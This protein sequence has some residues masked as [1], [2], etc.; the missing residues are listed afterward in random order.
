METTQPAANSRLLSLDVFRGLAVAAMIVVNTPGNSEIYRQLDHSEWGGCTVADLVFPFFLFI[1]GVSLV[2]SLSRRIEKGGDQGLIPQILKRAA[3]IYCL[4][5]VLNA[6]PDY[7]LST[8][9]MTG[10]LQRI[11]ICYGITAILFIRTGVK[12]Q[13]A[14]AAAALLGYWLAMTYIPVPE[15]G[16]GL[17]TKE[18]SLASYLDRLI[19][20]RHVYRQGVYD[21]EGILST[22]PALATAMLGVF[23]GLWLRREGEDNIKI[24]GMY[25]GGVA[26]VSTG[27]IWDLW[28]PINKALWTSSYVLYTGGLALFAL[29]VCYL[30]IDILD[31][32][33]W[34]RPFEIF[35]MN[36]IA[37]Y[38]LPILLLKFLVLYKLDAPG[39]EPVQLR[40]WLCDRLFGAWLSP[41]NAS[42]AFAV[43]YTLLWLSVFWLLYKR[44]IFIKI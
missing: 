19:L 18:G 40:I 11:A 5:M 12:T 25:L 29:A 9:R 26:L 14:A 34:G 38:M 39:G 30:L 31:I 36:A 41:I 2:F 6:I 16:P 4:G 10:V 13:I 1:A 15:F 22:V 32:K 3:I 42:A 33:A 21:P 17:L 8:I 20:G 35:G 28:F 43:S 7:Q 23:T 24:F 27:Y 44:K 37:A